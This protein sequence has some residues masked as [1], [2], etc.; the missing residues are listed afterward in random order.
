MLYRQSGSGISVVLK[1][2]AFS[3]LVRF[4]HARSWWHHEEK[5][6]S[7]DGLDLAESE[8]ECASDMVLG[9]CFAPSGKLHLTRLHVLKTLRSQHPN[10]DI[11]LPS[12]QPE[13][14]KNSVEGSHIYITS[15]LMKPEAGLDGYCIQISVSSSLNSKY[16]RQ[17]SKC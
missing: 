7:H 1:L 11:S 2:P 8:K 6:G 9:Y 3:G 16:A 5:L 12:D 17:S 10:E 4:D 15:T 13:W 14:K